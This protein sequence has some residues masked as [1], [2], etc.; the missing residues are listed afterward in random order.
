MSLVR[1]WESGSNPRSGAL[2][3]GTRSYTR[4]ILMLVDSTADNVVSIYGYLASLGIYWGQYYLITDDSNT[5]VNYDTGAF[6]IGIRP[7]RRADHEFLWDIVIDYGPYQ[8]P[9]G[10]FAGHPLNTPARSGG[11]PQQNPNIEPNPV[12]RRPIIQWS[13]IPLEAP[14]VCDANGKPVVNSAGQ[15]F[16][17]RRAKEKKIRRLQI[18]RNELTFDQLYL[19]RFVETVNLT[20]F[21]DYGAGCALMSDINA[22]SAYEGSVGKYWEVTYVID[23]KRRYPVGPTYVLPGSATPV[24][25]STFSP[26]CELIVDA[27]RENELGNPLVDTKGRPASHDMPLNGDGFQNLPFGTPPFYIAFEGYPSSDF[28]LLGLA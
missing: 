21:Y 10:P 16:T 11:D 12:S 18:T 26:W 15:P 22:R 4:H 1:L 28:G 5:L 3:A 20:A 24:L 13:M 2:T 7:T 25:P 9:G 6:I 27:G 19:D 8:L 23:I 14:M 17:G